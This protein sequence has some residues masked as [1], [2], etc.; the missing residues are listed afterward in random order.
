MAEFVKVGTIADIAPGKPLVHDFDYD[1]VVIFQVDNAY[2]CLEDICSHQEVELSGGRV[3][4]NAATDVCRVECPKHGSW[5]DLKTGE[6]LN[7]P[8]V[9]PVKTFAVKLD[10]DDILVEEPASW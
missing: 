5:F 7:M 10:G 6:A 4:C 3:E 9:S 1:T 8:A 2:Y